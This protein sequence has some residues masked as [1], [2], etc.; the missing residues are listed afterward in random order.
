MLENDITV[1]ITTYER[2]SSFKKALDSVLNQSYKNFELVVVDDNSID[3][4]AEEMLKKTKINYKYIK[5]PSNKGIAET[6]NIGIDE[7][8]S[9]IICFLD[10]DDEYFPD[11][12]KNTICT[13]KD[14]P[15]DVV[16]SWSNA[17]INIY[18]NSQHSPS[19]TK[20]KIFECR[21]YAS[22]MDLL[23]IGTGYGVALKR[24]CF[25]KIGKFDVTFK[26]TEDT[27]FFV[28][29]MNAGFKCL[30]NQDINIQINHHIST[31]QTSADNDNL[32]IFET[33]LIMDKYCEFFD[34]NQTLKLEMEN[35]ITLLKNRRN[36]LYSEKS[37]PNQFIASGTVIF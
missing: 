34:S 6:R 13:L 14:T 21:E 3:D 23:S 32:R 18:K 9:P 15:E 17:K 10:D 31:R 5:N 8:T 29:L 1:V 26:V 37:T 12:L 27:E 33:T 16:M 7:A 11:F 4:Y 24:S 28:R 30:I 25:E 35:Y 2:K 22:Y 20:N 36:Q 19:L